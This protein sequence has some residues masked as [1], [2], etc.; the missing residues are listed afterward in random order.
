MSPLILLNSMSPSTS[1]RSEYSRYS[2][3]PLLSLYYGEEQPKCERVRIDQ[4]RVSVCIALPRKKKK[5]KR[6]FSTT[7]F[8]VSSLTITYNKKPT[9][10]WFNEALQWVESE[11]S[12]MERKK[13]RKEEKG[14]LPIDRTCGA[15]LCANQ[16]KQIKSLA[17]VSL[18]KAE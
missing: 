2:N 16:H 10:P 12:K 6:S 7:L 9:L 15:C 17:M 8:A 18:E 13:E 14:Q 1:P 11:V 4:V 3:T 5:K